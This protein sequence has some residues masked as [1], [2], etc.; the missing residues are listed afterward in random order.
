MAESGT[1]AGSILSRASNAKAVTSGNCSRPGH[2]VQPVGRVFLVQL[3]AQIGHNAGHVGGADGL[4]PDL[5][6]R[7]VGFPRLARG[8]RAGIMDYVVMMAQPERDGVCPRRAIS[9]SSGAAS[10]RGRRRQAG[11]LASKPGCSRLV[12]HLHVRCLGDGPEG[13]GGGPV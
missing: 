3:A 11:A 1:E 5:F 8:G 2:A 6:Q 13:I 4:D 7:V 10:A 12:S 9:P